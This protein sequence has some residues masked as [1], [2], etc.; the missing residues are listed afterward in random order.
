MSKIAIDVMSGDHAPVEI[1]K[2]CIEASKETDATL[3][4][5]GNKEIIIKEFYK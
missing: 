5:V 1:I 4:L 2:G 3:I